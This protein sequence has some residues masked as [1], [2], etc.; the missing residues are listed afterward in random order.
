VIW[1]GNA[2]EVAAGLT[3]G[4]TGV[5][6]GLGLVK[7]WVL[8]QRRSRAERSIGV[9]TAPVVRSATKPVDDT[10]SD[11]GISWLEA[12]ASSSDMHGSN[13]IGRAILVQWTV[14]VHGVRQGV[15]FMGCGQPFYLHLVTFHRWRRAVAVRAQSRCLTYDDDHL[16]AT[17]YA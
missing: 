15:R 13:R 1:T 2:G 8:V 6:E 12:S 9:K 5:V 10:T 16:T 4:E 3:T 14:F 11:G 17:E 7:P